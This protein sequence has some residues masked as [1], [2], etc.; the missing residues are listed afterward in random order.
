M[1]ARREVRHA[2]GH[3]AAASRCGTPARSASCTRSGM[4]QPNRV[5][6]PGDGGDGARRA[7]D[8]AADRLARPRARACAARGDGVPGDADRRIGLAA[9]RSPGPAPSWRCARSTASS[10]SRRVGRPRSARRWTRALE[11]PARGRARPRW[12]ARRRRRSTRSA[13]PPRR[14]GRATARRRTAPRTP[15]PTS[16]T[17]CS[18]IARLIKA[19]RRPAGGGASTTATGTCTSAWAA[20]RRLDAR[21]PRP[22][23]SGALAAFATDL[24]AALD[25]VTLVTL[26]EFGGGVRGERL[27][28]RAT[29]ATARPCCCWAAA[30]GAARCT[31]RW[32]GLRARRPRRRRPRRHH[33]LPPVLAEVLVRRCGLASPRG[34]VPRARA[35]SRRGVRAHPA[36]GETGGVPPRDGPTR[37]P[38]APRSRAWRA[39]PAAAPADARRRRPLVAGGT[40]RAPRGARHQVRVPP[41]GAVQCVEGPPAHPRD[42]AERRRDRPRD[43]ARARLRCPRLGRR[44][45]VRAGAGQ[46]FPGGPVRAPAVTSQ[47]AESGARATC[48]TGGDAVRGRRAAVSASGADPQRAAVPGVRS[49]RVGDATRLRHRRRAVLDRAGGGAGSF[50]P[51]TL[52]GY[53]GRIGCSSA[54]LL[55]GAVARS[56][57]PPAYAPTGRREA[58]RPWLVNHPLPPPS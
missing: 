41:F 37:T 18:D 14:S 36:V 23:S 43:L 12:R 39:D 38:A 50:S 8:L 54:R 52:T 10:W 53:I 48:P 20:G 46:R 49:R 13:R 45:R 34:R 25:D 47:V 57:R 17:R 42:A 31:A 44:R 51:A 4:A 15:T 5:A 24:G 3:G 11:R 6:L 19:E 22:S 26:T 2:P 27:G 1:P 16:A 29:T 21:P 35:R 7:R 55:G 9:A 58:R 28:R 32:P 56:G 30:C 40:R 33:R